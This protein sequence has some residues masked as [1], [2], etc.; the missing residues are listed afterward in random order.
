MRLQILAGDKQQINTSPAASGKLFFATRT[1]P[2][3]QQEIAIRQEDFQKPLSKTNNINLSFPAGEIFN[4]SL[5]I[6][7]SIYVVLSSY[8]LRAKVLDLQELVLL[9][10]T[11]D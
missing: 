11:F 7:K 8:Q 1:D 2:D 6:F 9:V 4:H 5:F 10:R 3:G